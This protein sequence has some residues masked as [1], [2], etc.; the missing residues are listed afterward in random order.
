MLNSL[1]LND[2]I[3]SLGLNV[4][5]FEQAIGVNYSRI[6][7]AIRRK[8][9]IKQDVADKIIK[10]FPN[11]SKQWLETGEGEM[12]IQNIPDIKKRKSTDKKDVN[13]EITSDNN[14]IS[15]PLTE[16]QMSMK[17]FLKRLD[18]KDEQMDRL[19]S[20]IEHVTG[21]K[22]EEAHEH[23]GRTGTK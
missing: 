16:K 19:I 12:F 4:T 5:Q 20:I 21:A 2:L 11:V 15:L 23:L 3:L 1:Y 9:Y 7:T 22:K 10:V 18:K 6:A 17:D 8:T 13:I 14:D